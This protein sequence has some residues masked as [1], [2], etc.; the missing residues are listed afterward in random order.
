MGYRGEKTTV[1]SNTGGNMEA[2]SEVGNK[3]KVRS[4]VGGNMGGSIIQYL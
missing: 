3:T 2:I 4:E 1:R